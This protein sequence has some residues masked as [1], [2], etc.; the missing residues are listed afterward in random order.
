MNRVSKINYWIGIAVAAVLLLESAFGIYSFIHSKA[1]AQ[2]FQQRF[3]QT[4]QQAP[5]FSDQD[6]SGSQSGNSSGPQM[7]RNFPNGGT[8][9][10]SRAL[11]TSPGTLVFHIFTLLLSAA[12]LVMTAIIARNNA[13]KKKELGTTKELTDQQ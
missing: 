11:Q 4:S 3:P 7:N 2:S 1:Q 9:M 13:R 8:R 5:D 6:N 10:Q 12:A